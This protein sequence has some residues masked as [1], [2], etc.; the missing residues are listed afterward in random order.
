MTMGLHGWVGRL[1]QRKRAAGK[2]K[3]KAF[4]PRRCELRTKYVTKFDRSLMERVAKLH[5]NTIIRAREKPG[6][7]AICKV[8]DTG[9]GV[10]KEVYF[11]EPT[12]ADERAQDKARRKMRPD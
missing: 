5:P 11:A 9:R 4:K 12:L 7:F 10:V 8:K 1:I 6:Y 3:P 2:Q